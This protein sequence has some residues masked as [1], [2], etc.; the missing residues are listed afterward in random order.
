M[1][2]RFIKYFIV[3][4]FSTMIILP[5]C[6]KKKKDET[7]L[8]M[9]GFMT[10]VIPEYVLAGSTV[11]AISGG[12]ITT[13]TSGLS[14]MWI[15]TLTKD[16][17]TM[18]E[19]G[20]YYFTAPDTLAK[21]NIT[22]TALADGYYNTIQ[23]FTI[24]TIVPY[25]GGS[26]KNVAKPTDSIQDPRDGQFYYVEE[27]GNLIWFSENL[28]YQEKGAGFASSDD[29]GYVLG[30]LYTWED[31]TDGNSGS[32]LGEGPQ[33]MC[34]PG[35]SVPTNEDWEDLANTIGDDT[36]SFTDRWERLGERLIPEKATFNGSRLWPFSVNNNPS[37]DY[38]WNALSGGY[39][40]HT[41]NYY[42]GLFKYAFFW[43]STES[44]SANAYYRYLY[45]DSADFPFSTT[46]KNGLGA[47]VRCVKKK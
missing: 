28:N 5:G 2:K 37:N 46:P 1:K 7:K 18:G 36:Y 16:T 12:G 45:Y 32:G 41:Y 40:L 19:G 42:E 47:S 6:H 39:S 26:L 30:R 4:V 11:S 10:S 43:S 3:A 8:Y 15:N 27:I 38:K 35:W 20:V 23:T 13:P 34:P 22:Q 21:F 9:D 31:A 17:I 14:Y 33:G 25:I 24:N 44:D 29:V